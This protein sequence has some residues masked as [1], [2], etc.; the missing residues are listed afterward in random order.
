MLQTSW[1]VKVIR[2]GAR[3][4]DGTLPPEV[5]REKVICPTLNAFDNSGDSRAVVTIVH[6]IQ[7]TVIG[8]ADTAGPQGKGYGEVED[9]MFTVDT[10]SAHAVSVT[11]IQDARELDKKQNGLGVA[12]AGAPAYTVDTISHQAV[13]FST[14]VRRLT[15]REC[16][17]LQGFPDTKKSAIIEVCLDSQKNP[18]SVEILNLKWQSLVGNVESE[19]S[20]ERVPSAVHI[21]DINNP[22]IS[23]PVV[24]IVLTNYGGVKVELHNQ[25][26]LIWS[27]NSAKSQNL[28]A[29][30]EKEDF[31]QA[32]VGLMQI[33]EQI[34]SGGK[35][36]LQKIETSLI[37]A[38]SGK[39]LEK[40]SGSA[41]TP[42]ASDVNTDS[43]IKS[44]HTMFITSSLTDSPS[45]EL[46]LQ[47]SFSFVINAIIGFIPQE[48]LNESSLIFQI[49]TVEGW[50][51]GQSDSARYK[52]MGNAV[53]ANVVEWIGK[54]L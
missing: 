44:N 10:S 38:E 7:N 9:P 29:L 52:Q 27:A 26:K 4:E 34:T 2:S 30:L 41:I 14:T 16:E 20:K 35:V 36:V 25:G 45:S 21:L 48:I 28:L 24:K 6:S 15:P 43:T 53:T 54:R 22:S 8:R 51:E 47:T 49:D 42:L 13:S 12:Q 32:I 39:R 19:G 5:W 11:P 1:F 37:P 50:T 17:R 46:P 18:A 23:K 3:Y 33:V 40:L 31:A